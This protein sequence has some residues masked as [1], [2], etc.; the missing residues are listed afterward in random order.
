MQIQSR[1]GRASRCAEAVRRSARDSATWAGAGRR[2]RQPQTENAEKREEE[3]CSAA[4]RRPT[5]RAE[6]RSVS[7]LWRVV[8]CGS[9][10]QE[11]RRTEL[12]FTSR[13]PFDDQHW[14]TAFGAEP[15]LT[16]VMGG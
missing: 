4:R 7:E 13:K 3:I 16:C 11:G 12:D 1:E 8:S 6:A 5:N 15:K 9:G 10:D 2:A 14:S